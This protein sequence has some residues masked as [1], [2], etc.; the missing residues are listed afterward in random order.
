MVVSYLNDIIIGFGEV[1]K[2]DFTK[3]IRERNK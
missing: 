3:F 2:N 1:G